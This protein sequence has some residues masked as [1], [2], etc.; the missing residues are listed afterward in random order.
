MKRIWAIALCV[1]L[2]AC[3]A[4][5]KLD[6]GIAYRQSQ[7]AYKA[8][9]QNAANPQACVRERLIMEADERAF[10]NVS[11]GYGGGATSVNATVSGR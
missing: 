7:A 5:A 9:L 6:T 3:G 4:V 8:C 2:A 1:P 10:T 11:A